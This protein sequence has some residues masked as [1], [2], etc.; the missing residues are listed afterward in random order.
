MNKNIFTFLTSIFVLLLLITYQS[1]SSDIN[2]KSKILSS[3]ELIFNMERNVGKMPAINKYWSYT[4]QVANPFST[5]SGRGNTHKGILNISLKSDTSKIDTLY[6]ESDKPYFLFRSLP[7]AGKQNPFPDYTQSGA[8]YNVKNDNTFDLELLFKPPNTMKPGYY[9]CY[10]SFFG[11]GLGNYITVQIPIYIYYNPYEWFDYSKKPGIEIFVISNKKDT[12]N[13]IFGSGYYKPYYD[14]FTYYGE[15]QYQT[16]FS[17][18][19]FEARFFTSNSKYPYGIGDSSPNDENP[20]SNSRDIQYFVNASTPLI[21]N[22]KINSFANDYPIKIEY[23]DFNF[24]EDALFIMAENI[25]LNTKFKFD[26]RN[27]PKINSTR[28]QY[29][30]TDTSIKEFYIVYYQSNKLVIHTKNPI[31]MNHPYCPD[32][33]F[34]LSFTTYQ[35]FNDD[36]KFIAELSDADGSWLTNVKQ[37]GTISGKTSGVFRLGF[38]DDVTEGSNFKVRVNSTSPKTYGEENALPLDIY[39]AV[40]DIIKDTIIHKKLDITIYPKS[41][42]LSIFYVYD[43]PTG[44]IEYHSQW[45]NFSIYVFKDTTVYVEARSFINNCHTLTRA[46]MTVRI[47][48]TSV[49]LNDNLNL[50]NEFQIIPNPAA[51]NF[52]VKIQSLSSSDADLALYNVFGAKILELS[53]IKINPGMNEIPVNLNDNFSQGLYFV[54]ISTK[55]ADY[56]EKLMIIGL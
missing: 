27:I 25:D 56:T 19:D 11:K 21:Y 48:P 54:H 8:A 40:P 37:L 34:D 31:S 20:Y 24:P 35:I 7:R 18:A 30:I 13:L 50:G 52:T 43:T 1:I 44:G 51:N 10:M 45:E 49:D 5:D 33:S 46:K 29:I 6:I 16:P 38:P 4:W 36:N 15:S 41:P 26:M 47:I 12:S 3:A 9:I 42:K 55:S 28:Y 32:D 17:L 39:P 14:D 53:N 22:I 23:D 2:D